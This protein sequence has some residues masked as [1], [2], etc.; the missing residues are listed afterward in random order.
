MHSVPFPEDIFLLN[1]ISLN[2]N[3]S[4]QEEY[5]TEI[6]MDIHLHHY[7]LRDYSCMLAEM[8]NIVK[9]Y[10]KIGKRNKNAI[11]HNKLGK[12]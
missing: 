6:Y 12:P 5:D 10:T 4:I 3:K 7:P 1:A 2:V 9:E 11:E 8:Q